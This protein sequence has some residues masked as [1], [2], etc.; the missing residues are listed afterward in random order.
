[1]FR[2]VLPVYPK[3]LKPLCVIKHS[4]TR[5][6]ITLTAYTASLARRPPNMAGKWVKLGKLQEL[7][8][9]AAHKKMVAKMLAQEPAGRI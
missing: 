3:T 9:T 7:A 4:I 1:M 8:F 5:Y 2:L 6:R